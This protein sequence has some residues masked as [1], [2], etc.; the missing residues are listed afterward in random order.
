MEGSCFGGDLQFVRMLSSDRVDWASMCAYKR[1]AT[2]PPAE[3][4][5][6]RREQVLREGSSSR[7]ERRRAATG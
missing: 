7:R 5:V 3:W 4:P 2:A 6:I 1:L